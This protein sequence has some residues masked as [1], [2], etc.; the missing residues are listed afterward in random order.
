V[1]NRYG[2]AVIRAVLTTCRPT[3]WTKNLL[4]AAAP[5]AAGTLLHSDVLLRTLLTFVVMT[6][7]AAAAYCLNDVIDAQADATHPTKSRRPIASGALPPAVA[8][9]VAGVLAIGA[10]VLAT[11]WDLRWVVLAYLVLTAAYS[12][13]LKHQAVVELGVVASGFLL[14]AVAGGPATGT[15]LSQWFLIV[16]AFGSLFMVAGK[17]LSELVSL[18]GADP[19]SRLLL[20]TYTASYLRMVVGISASVTIAAYCLWAFEVGARHDP[21]VPWA[22]ISVAPLVIAILRYAL[23]VDRGRAQEPEQI[24]LRDRVLQGLG[25]LWL[26]TFALTVLT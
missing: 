17:R 10:L 11:P 7:A 16:A 12:L 15:P 2:A 21:T 22:A 9:S 23:D 19:A 1:H 14:R 20:A 4:V 25:L 18:D 13:G 3:Q 5:L 6:M 26:G 8:L 24:V